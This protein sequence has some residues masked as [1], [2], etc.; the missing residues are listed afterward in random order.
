MQKLSISIP[1]DH[2]KAAD[3]IHQ[4]LAG[5][6]HLTGGASSQPITGCWLNQFHVLIEEPV[7][8]VYTLATE[9]QASSVQLYL[10]KVAREIKGAMQQECVL[11]TVEDIK[12]A[13][14]VS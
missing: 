2:E 9:S 4:T 5:L 7:T 6:S 12:V 13:T 8:V 1:T 3:Y 14:F 11:V 10:Q